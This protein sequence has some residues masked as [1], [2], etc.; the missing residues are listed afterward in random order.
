MGLYLTIFDDD[1]EI[2]GVEIGLYS[3]FNYFRNLVVSQLEDGKVGVK[4]P[5]LNLH[6]DCDGTWSVEESIRLK[7][8]LKDISIALKKFPPVKFNSDWQRKV[9]KSHGIVP[10]NLQDCFFDVDGEPLLERL[11]KLCEI[12]QQKNLPILFQ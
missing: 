6:S 8:E 3:D 2:E 5:M 11:I 7:E 4:Y 12:S 10:K 9:A 1:E